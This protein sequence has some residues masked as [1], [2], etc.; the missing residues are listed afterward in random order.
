MN[1]LVLNSGED[2]RRARALHNGEAN[3]PN[4]STLK[5]A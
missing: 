5:R 3:D 1:T 4:S 2:A